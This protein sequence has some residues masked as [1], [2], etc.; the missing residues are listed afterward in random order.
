[1][2]L[3]NEDLPILNIE[4]REVGPGH[5]MFIVGEVG[6]AHDGSLAMAEAYV[7]SIARAG[8]D[9]VKF[10]THIAE[11]ESTPH[12]PFRVRLTTGDVSRL[13]YWRRTGFNREQWQT[14]VQNARERGLAFLSSPFSEAAVDLLEELNVAAY[15]VASGE[16]SNTS[17]LDRILATRKPLLLST[18]MSRMDEVDAVVARLGE[19]GIQ[20]AV[21]QCTSLYPCPPERIGLNLLDVFRQ[22]YRSPVGLSDHSGR[23]FAGLA[24][25]ALGCDI[26]EIHVTISRDMPGPDVGSSLTV[27]ELA[28]LVQGVRN[29]EAMLANP[30]VKDEVAGELEPMKRIFAHSVVASTDLPAGTVIR[31]EHLASK[32]P[33]T[34]LPPSAIPRIVGRRLTRPIAADTA[35]SE[36]DL[37]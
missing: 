21:M 17:L 9:A 20:F 16:T 25:A 14:L 5:P 37:E 8:A 1:M 28:F 6:M 27:D 12:E 2:E 23:V 36:E 24:A 31:A 32:K 7:R 18:G 10:Q 3:T 34:G 33:G 26:L 19:S 22:K 11:A 4:G 13:D 15:K 30:V 35:L 29:I